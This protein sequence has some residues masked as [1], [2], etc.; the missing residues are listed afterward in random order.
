MA[1]VLAFSAT[2]TFVLPSSTGRA[3]EDPNPR[4][5]TPA[6][7]EA[8]RHRGEIGRAQADL[9]LA[10][11]LGPRWGLVP[12]RFR[13]EVPWDGT[14]PLLHLRDRVANMAP[15]PG[16][17]AI[18][19]E[20]SSGAAGSCG[21]AT[22]GTNTFASTYFSIDYQ[23]IRAGLTINSYATSLD[24]ARTKEVNTFG[25]AAPPLVPSAPSGR[26]HV[27][28]DNLAPGLYGFVS[29]SGTYAGNIGGNNPNTS[30]NDIDA[31]ASCMALND[32]YSGFPSPPQATLDSTTAHE[33]NHS[34]QFGYGALTG[35]NRPD[36]AFIEGGATWMED[37]VF[38]GANDNYFYLW[39]DFT[40]DMGSYESHLPASQ[41]FPYPYWITFR[42]LTERFGTGAA[43][44]GEQVMQDFWELTSQSGTSNMLPALNEALASKGTNLADAY[45]AF[46]IAARFNRTC[47]GGYV[48][49][50]CFE[51]AVGYVANA[52]STA[53]HRAIVGVGGS[54]TG[55][56]PDHYSLNWVALPAPGP[57]DVTLLNTSTGGQLRGSA[58]CDTGSALT[59]TP[60]PAVVGPSASTTLAGYNP[61]SCTQ[62]VL[63][64]T[65]QAQPSSNPSSSMGRGYSVQTAPPGSVVTPPET[66]ITHGRTV[67]L[68]LRKHIVARGVVTAVDG[69]GACAA[70]EPVR[71]ERKKAGWKLVK[72]AVTD[73]SGRYKVR[74]GDRE[75]R[76]RAVLAAGAESATDRCGAA[77]S[78]PR[79]HRH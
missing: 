47:G 54:V 77:F 36:D 16:R 56:V 40:D 78:P 26:Y 76:Y 3:S 13:S 72:G 46:A 35:G 9:F 30:W 27:V 33:F 68:G 45:H 15:G 67:S 50:H 2:A 8:A 71:I 20:L 75:G 4:L 64:I 29:S 59:I 79:R 25:W 10:R 17:S 52:G 58:V 32:D 34:I 19:E 74:L 43:N 63:T 69:F 39:P 57:Y 48:Y 53:V 11:A 5:S 73:G 41:Q 65:N 60:F 22:G 18:V 1:L 70:G 6:L 66:N 49:P 55:S 14:L 24:A 28:V 44:A 42:G 7:I 21:A 23:T 61:S 12:D 38:D 37:E 62:V 51:E 31:Q